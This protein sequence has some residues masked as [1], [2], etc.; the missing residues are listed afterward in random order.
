MQNS[1]C[2]LLILVLY[3]LKKKLITVAYERTNFWTL[4][5]Q[6]G[7]KATTALDY[8]R[9]RNTFHGDYSE[10][11]HRKYSEI[12]C[13]AA[14]PFSGK[15][16][17]NHARISFSTVILGRARF[18]WKFSVFPFVLTYSSTVSFHKSFT[19]LPSNCLFGAITLNKKLSYTFQQRTT[20]G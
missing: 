10:I 14:G 15:T 1:I 17:D 7:K 5:N 2:L 13:A 4:W 11:H 19:N 20:A 16:K 9:K 8:A 3:K 18:I 12:H 6:I